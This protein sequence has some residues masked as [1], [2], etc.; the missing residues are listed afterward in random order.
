MESFRQ[1][2]RDERAASSD[3]V[4][5]MNSFS[6]DSM[7]AS[8]K[9]ADERKRMDDSK[10]SRFVDYERTLYNT[11]GARHMTEQH[12][13]DSKVLDK[14]VENMY[15][16][17]RS[18]GSSSPRLTEYVPRVR[19]ITAP[20]S[21]KRDVKARYIKYLDKSKRIAD[22]ESVE[23]AEKAAEDAYKYQAKL[24][25]ESESGDES[26]D[27]VYRRGRS[28]SSVSDALSDASDLSE[29]D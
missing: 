7:A 13:R 3:Y 15:G 29:L 11:S 28:Y 5:N 16:A 19:S 8:L 23:A 1:M 2:L 6:R 14:Y 27:G 12:I 9:H 26:D 22:G 18:G 17:K 4:K 24:Y 21:V 25:A 20:E 10:Y